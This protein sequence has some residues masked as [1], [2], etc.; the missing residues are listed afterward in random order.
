MT[1]ALDVLVE[2]HALLTRGLT[3]LEVIAERVGRGTVVPIGAVAKLTEFFRG[4]VQELHQSKEEQV[5][6]PM[7]ERLG[8]P[9]TPL[10]ALRVEHSAARRSLR[11][12]EVAMAD[13]GVSADARRRFVEEAAHFRALLVDHV[14]RE[15]Q[16]LFIDARRLLTEHPAESAGLDVAFAGYDRGAIASG[17]KARF[18]Q[19]LDDLAAQ[20][21]LGGDSPLATAHG[22]RADE[23]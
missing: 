1:H 20:F 15:E 7:L 11:A 17:R 18:G 2:E 10:A 23:P 12:L 8:Q 3:I 6:F 19:W 16:G 9:Q 13:L 21:L 4:F 5:L 22:S 14:V